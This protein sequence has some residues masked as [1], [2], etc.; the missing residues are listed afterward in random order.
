MESEKLLEELIKFC[1]VTF[2]P[3]N[4]NSEIG[5]EERYKAAKYVCEYIGRSYSGF[6]TYEEFMG[7]VYSELCK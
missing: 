1:K 2:C 4:S 3:H 5:K 7:Y 6:K